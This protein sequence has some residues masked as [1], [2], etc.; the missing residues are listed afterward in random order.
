[1]ELRG[2]Y[3]DGKTA[4]KREATVWVEN[5]GLRIQ[6]AEEAQVWWPYA[7]VRQNRDH[8]DFNQIR[9][10]KGGPFPEIL[11]VP[12]APFFSTLRQTFPKIPAPFREPSN[13]SLRLAFPVLAALGAIGIVLSLY[14]WGIPFLTTWAASRVPV[15][16]E[17]NLG[18]SIVESLAP[19]EVRCDAPA[20]EPILQDVIGILTA[21]LPQRPYKF[22]IIVVDEPEINAFAAPGGTIV[23]Y[24]GLLERIKSREELAGVLAHEMQH[25]LHRHS[26]RI[27]LRNISLG[28]LFSVVLGD[29][30]SAIRIGREG[31]GI[32]GT[33]N[34]SRQYE[35]QADEEGIRL[36]LAA[37]IDPKG[38]I[39]FFEE[40]EKEDQKAVTI[41]AYFS[42]HP[43]LKS[44]IARLKAIAQE[45]PLTSPRPFPRLELPDA[46]EICQ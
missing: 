21:S 39:S 7:E 45:N 23:L 36:L 6:L 20:H 38:M 12:K 32:L 25:I 46:E 5:D 37:G 33:L 9:M 41:P 22:Q 35:E 43:N 30:N 18:R 19:L 27:L 42:T 40:I 17:E 11:I 31:A 44:R 3:L 26:T 13:I 1:M 24:R 15:S 8:S 10:E 4:E 28:L 16:W 2:Y 34:Y 29:A 14:L